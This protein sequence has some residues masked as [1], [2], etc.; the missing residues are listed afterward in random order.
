MRFLLALALLSIATLWLATAVAF[1]AECQPTE[2]DSLQ[3][4]WN[5]PCESGDWLFDTEAGC[6]MWDWHPDPMDTV[7]WTGVCQNGS[8]EGPGIVQWF[9]HAEPIDRFEGF[10]H[11]GQRKGFGRYSWTA[12]DQYE[13]Q[14]EADLPSGYGTVRIGGESFSGI[15]HHGCL[16]NRDR[17]IA[18]G[19]R[20]SSCTASPP[21]TAAIAERFE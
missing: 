18:I 16:Q 17:I 3:V 8:K 12:R 4:S 19:A 14:Y 15:W 5:T 2:P 6:R 1:A 11:K 21:P 10:F 20:L 9:E 7:T 13:G